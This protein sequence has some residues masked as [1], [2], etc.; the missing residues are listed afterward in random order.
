LIHV[1]DEV[2][3]D[4]KIKERSLNLLFL[5]AGVP[6]MDRSGMKILNSLVYKNRAGLIFKYRNIGASPLT[7]C[8][9]LLF[10]HSLHHQSPSFTIHFYVSAPCRHCRRR[11]ARRTH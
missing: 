9:E 7:H 3:K 6:S 2:C 11:W 1:V 4:I 10:S 5:S 8:I